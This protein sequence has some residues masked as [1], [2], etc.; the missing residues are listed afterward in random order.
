MTE[1][2]QIIKE[3]IDNFEPD[4][5][6]CISVAIG[7]PAELKAAVAQVITYMP[8]IEAVYSFESDTHFIFDDYI[9]HKECLE[10]PVEK[11]HN[12]HGWY[13]KHD[14]KKRY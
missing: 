8:H 11:I 10:T 7:H 12:Q 6:I 13:R 3:R 5:G 14:K 2:A 1:L 4:K 9:K